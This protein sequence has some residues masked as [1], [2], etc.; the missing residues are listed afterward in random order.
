MNYSPFKS[1]LLIFLYSFFLNFIWEHVHSL[2][3]ASYKGGRLTEFILF[4][5]SLGD[6]VILS[7]LALPF[8]FSS[9]FRKRLWII[10]PIG[11]FI[12]IIIEIY[13]LQAG[14]WEYNALMP[15]IPFLNIGLTPTIQLALTGYL[16]YCLVLTRK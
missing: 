14:R 10:I 2:L 3:Y 16:T 9:F 6:A 15:I 13:A 4:H 1:L 5:A 7:L 12:A 8:I 11:I